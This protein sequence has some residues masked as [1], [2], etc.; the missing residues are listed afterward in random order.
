MHLAMRALTKVYPNGARAVD[1]LQLDVAEGE[2]LVLLGPSGCGKSTVLRLIA[3]LESVS[4]GA[5]FIAGRIANHLPP[6]DRDIAMVIVKNME[7]IKKRS[8]QRSI[9]CMQK[10]LLEYLKKAFLQS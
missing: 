2:F 5:L 10:D 7:K 4:S 3:G 9:S 6:Q 8:Q 1:E